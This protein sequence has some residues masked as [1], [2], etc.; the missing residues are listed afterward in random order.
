MA[1]F[2]EITQVP[3]SQRLFPLF[4][5][6]LLMNTILRHFGKFKENRDGFESGIL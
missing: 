6:Q 2:I 3:L 1:H 4:N 5:Y